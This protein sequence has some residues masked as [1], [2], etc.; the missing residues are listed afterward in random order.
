M[1]I[2]RIFSLSKSI[3][4]KLLTYI[5][6]RKHCKIFLSDYFMKQL[7]HEIHIKYAKRKPQRLRKKEFKISLRPATLIKKRLCGRCFP[8]KFLKTPFLRNAS[9]RLLLQDRKEKHLF[10]G[11]QRNSTKEHHII[12]GKYVNLYRNTVS[13][14][15]RLLGVFPPDYN[16]EH[17]NIPRKK[18]I[19]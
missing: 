5:E 13:N 6:A 2:D 1:G 11:K 7:F 10:L 9:R 15:A 4:W 18:A 8:A 12:T 16:P 17:V 19:F 14:F 3:V